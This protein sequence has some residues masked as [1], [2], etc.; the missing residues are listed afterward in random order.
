MDELP[1]ELITY[2]ICV[3]LVDIDRQILRRCSR[4]FNS[5]IPYKKI[6]WLDGPMEIVHLVRY[7]KLWDDRITA[8][9]AEYGNLECLKYAHYQGCPLDPE[10]TAWAAQYGHLDCLKYAHQNGRPLDPETTAC[11]AQNDHLEWL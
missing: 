3:F 8:W 2:G 11:A 6:K 1:E 10:T 4:Q 7:K 9:A 5:I